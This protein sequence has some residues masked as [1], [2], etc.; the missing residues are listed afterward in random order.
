MEKPTIVLVH[1]ADAFPDPDRSRWDDRKLDHV[2]PSRLTPRSQIQGKNDDAEHDGAQ[3]PPSWRVERDEVRCQSD[4]NA[5]LFPLFCVVVDP[6]AGRDDENYGED[7]HQGASEHYESG[8]GEGGIDD[9]QRERAAGPWR[10]RPSTRWPRTVRERVVA[11][12]RADEGMV[13]T[14]GASR[15]VPSR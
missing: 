11:G 1:G 6:Q 14:R 12:D 2:H 15:M 10:C 13:T 9:D 7:R 4:G 3:R 8:P 5:S